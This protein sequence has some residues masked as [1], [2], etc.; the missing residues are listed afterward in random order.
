MLVS[1]L[2]GTILPI[3]VAAVTKWSTQSW[4][5]ATLLLGLSGVT[6]LLTEWIGNPQINWVVAGVLA[7]QTFVIG[8]AL[9]FGLWKPTGASEAVANS[10]GPTDR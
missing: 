10:V 5:K 6:G 4:I 7:L 8:V 9:H 2:I 3:L 1:L